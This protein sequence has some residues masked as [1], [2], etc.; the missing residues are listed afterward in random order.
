MISIKKIIATGIIH[1]GFENTAELKN[2]DDR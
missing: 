2:K 1:V